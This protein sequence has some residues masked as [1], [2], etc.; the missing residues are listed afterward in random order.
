MTTFK[1][2][3][4]IAKEHAAETWLPS[5]GTLYVDPEG[6]EDGTAY[7][8]IIGARE[9][10]VDGDDNYLMLDD[11]ALI[12]DKDTGELTELDAL[13]DEQRLDAMTATW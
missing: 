8:V 3:M 5:D 7:L 13:K 6:Y 11:R 2:A 4:Q 9:C 10:L 1:Q 12:V